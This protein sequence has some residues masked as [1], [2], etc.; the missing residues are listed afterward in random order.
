MDCPARILLSFKLFSLFSSLI[1]VPLRLAMLPSVSPLR[2]VMVDLPFFEP[3]L[4][5]A[6]LC[7][8]RLRLRLLRWFLADLRRPT[9]GTSSLM[10]V[11][12]RLGS[13]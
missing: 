7:E 4:A 3:L 10:L 12:M 8:R 6:S 2:M 1:V 13:S 5:V 9:V 11:W